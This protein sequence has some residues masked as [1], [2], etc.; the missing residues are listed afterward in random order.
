[1]SPSSQPHELT[2]LVWVALGIVVVVGA[3]NALSEKASV[4]TLDTLHGGK[5]IVIRSQA[6]V[7][8]FRCLG[9]SVS[10][11]SGWSYLSI[12]EDS[13]A[14]RPSFVHEST[15]SLVRLQPYHFD[16]WPPEDLAAEPVVGTHPSGNIEWVSVDHRRLGRLRL[17]GIDVAVI[18]I[19]HDHKDQINATIKDFCHGIR[20][21]EFAD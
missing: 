11:P 4:E 1:M 14:D 5:P 8:R 9:V 7:H 16:S 6:A 15:H 20:H 2:P 21:L 18:A 3:V 12:A 19:Q 10:V 13:L 17:R